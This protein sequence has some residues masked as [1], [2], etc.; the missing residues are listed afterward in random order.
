[1]KAV[2][3]H[4]FSLSCLLVINTLLIF[5]LHAH[6]ESSDR[7]GRMKDK[8]KLMERSL[9]VN[10]SY[11]HNVGNLQM[12]ITNWGFLGSLPKSHYPMSDSPSAQW[13]AGSG[14]EY[15]YAAGLW[16]GAQRNGIPSVSTG[17]PE[18]EFYPTN[19][20]TDI[21]Y[22]SF[23][24]APGGSHYPGTGDDDFD[25][26]VDED[27]L[28]GRDDDEDGL[29]DEDFAAFGKQMFS[30]WYT[31]DQEQSSMIWPEHTPLNLHVRQ[32]TYQWSE[33]E[34]NDFIGVRYWVTN[35]GHDFLTNVYIGIYADFDAGPR[36][37][38]NYHMDDQVGS[39]E[40]IYCAPKGGA[41][42]PVRLR[43]AYVYDNDGDDEQT[44]GYFG[45]AL[46]NYPVY[47]D[48]VKL[49]AGQYVHLS[50]VR[51]FRGLQSFE[52]GG[53]PANDYERYSAMSS[54]R[55]DNNTETANDYKVLISAGPFYVLPPDSTLILDF[56]YVCGEGLD[57]MLQSAANAT[58]VFGGCW[59][60]WDKNPRTGIDG[61]ETPVPGPKA[62][63]Y[64]DPCNNPDLIVDIPAKSV[65]WSNLDCFEE[66]WLY[67]YSGC[68]KKI[69]A[70]LSYYMTG[71]DG[72]ET[73]MH[74]ITGSAPSP[75]NM[76]VLPGDHKVTIFWDN[77]SEI[78]PDPLTLEYDFE[79]YQI[80][81]A[82]DWHRPLGTSVL[83]GPEH[84]LWRLLDSRDL[85]NGVAPDVNF[86]KPVSE[87]GW[88]YKPLANLPDREKFIQMFEQSIWYA[89]YD[90]VPCPPGLS[91]EDCD[92]LEAIARHNLNFEGGKQYYE[93]VD[94]EAKNGLPYFYSVTAYDH[95]LINGEPVT[96]GRYDSP[97]SN[98]VFVSPRT[99]AQSAENFGKQEV[100]VVPNP[101]TTEGMEPWKMGPNNHDPT[102]IKLEFRNLPQCR[103]TVR[104]YTVSGD[105]V[106][107]LDH[108]G[109][110][111][112]G[113]LPWNLLTRN[114]QNIT[115][116]VYIFS[117]DS[118][119]G[120][121]PR[122]IGKFV[123]I[124]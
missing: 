46:L 5:F 12:N 93:Y 66:R 98:F 9:V 33:D 84:N 82:D 119:D 97:A 106:Q 45:I 85:V 107:T 75:P 74:W 105:L 22:R 49:P 116:G 59:V 55:K 91:D 110:N 111:G 61:R 37:R 62:D 77:Q 103:S 51:F 99:D 38:G 90:T 25:G 95:N 47:F 117:V 30:C 26:L 73:Q 8:F 20:P 4:R 78:A 80:W 114:G 86:K 41:Q 16:V 24:G 40:G 104:I 28:N 39:W 31:D 65:Y 63:W 14:V 13:P 122:T 2:R 29:I 44:P 120:R 96:T 112:N 34:F 54:M 89:P 92:T 57:G 23:E 64:P 52:N 118:D 6:T 43:I 19:N 67:E 121:F 71:V 113:T 115:S 42:I 58:V 15:L 87:G 76:R 109:K 18:T 100:Y 10:G 1:M 3:L 79:G 48:N 60:D 69:G 72:K 35:Q 94:T 17:Y 101:V 108:D 21:I 68:Y 36:N 32:E 50:T 7:S 123:V 11:I 124:R 81:R 70:G 56:A 83:T 53:E 88:E 102:G 27:W